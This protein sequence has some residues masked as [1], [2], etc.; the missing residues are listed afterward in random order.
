MIVI[1]VYPIN[2]LKQHVTKCYKA[3]G[4][5]PACLC[6][7]MPE[8]EEVGDSIIVIHNSFDGR[9]GVEWAEEILKYDQ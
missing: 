4:S 5:P 7:C 3:S 2:D 8:H 9:E 6:N 1:H